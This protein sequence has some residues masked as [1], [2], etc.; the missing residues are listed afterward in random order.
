MSLA[1]WGAFGNPNEML[2]EMLHDARLVSKTICEEHT[3]LE[4]LN[5]ARFAEQRDYKRRRV[6][7]EAR[8]LKAK[9]KVAALEKLVNIGTAE[10]SYTPVKTA[11][12][13]RLR[14]QE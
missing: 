6:E 9:A 12:W 4:C 1:L 13:L 5:A 2:Q 7:Q 14:L 10:M 11:E 8:M 3:L